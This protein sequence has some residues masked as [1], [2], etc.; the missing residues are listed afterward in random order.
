MADEKRVVY[1][2]DV[3]STVISVQSNALS[4]KEG[5]EDTVIATTTGTKRQRTLMDMF[6][7]SQTDKGSQP[8]AKKMKLTASGSSSN[9]NKITTRLG[10]QRL[11]SI[12]FSLSQYIASLP[13]EHKD[14]LKLECDCMGKSWLKVLK[15]EI[16][17]PYFISLKRFLWEEGVKGPSDSAKTLKVYPSPRNIYSW[18]NTPL[19]KVKVVIVGQDPYHGPNQAHGLCFS[20]PKGVAVPPSLRNIYA[21]IKAEYPAFEPPKHGNLATWA[22][23]GV[24]MLNTCLTVK[25]G[26]AGSHSGKGWEEFTDKVVDVVDRY[27]GANLAN[28]DSDVSGIGRGVVF[29]AWGAWAAKRV[30]K[31]NETKHLILKSAHPSPFSAHKGFI[32]NGHFKTA[33]EW[34]ERRYGREGTVD[35][36]DLDKPVTDESA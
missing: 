25:A 19:G 28:G 29:L 14:L 21:E 36:C 22:D 8:A 24:L 26:Q 34:L 13:E 32:G 5:T 12:P 35:W 9:L 11:N 27:G 6:P 2:E 4:G 18:S 23:N 33:N 1:L 30:A 3:E 16:K 20:V 10:T 15:D 7:G 17:K 31:L